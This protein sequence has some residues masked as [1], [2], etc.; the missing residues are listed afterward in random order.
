MYGYDYSVRHR[1]LTAIVY[2]HAITS[3]FAHGDRLRCC[4]IGPMICFYPFRSRK[5]DTSPCAEFDGATRGNDRLIGCHVF[6]TK[7]LRCCCSAL[8]RHR[9]NPIA[10]MRRCKGLKLQCCRCLFIV[11][12]AIM[13]PG[14][15]GGIGTAQVH[16]KGGVSADRVGCLLEWCVGRLAANW[17]Q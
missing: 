5:G 15:R 12:Y 9:T 4:T 10:S 17:Y 13:H 7:D 3:T 11:W 1:A 14:Y 8:V 6:Q 2:R 16:C